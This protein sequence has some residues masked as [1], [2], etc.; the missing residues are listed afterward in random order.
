M[1][2]LNA[3]VLSEEKQ[4]ILEEQLGQADMAALGEAGDLAPELPGFVRYG[5]ASE[6]GRSQQAGRRGRG[7]FWYV[8]SSLSTYVRKVAEGSHV[9]WV[10]VD[11]PQGTPWYVVAV[12]LPPA[13]SQQ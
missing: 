6:Q 3:N 13:S 5:S 7:L 1:L 8:R 12:Y 2:Y 4:A 9:L 11:L 10:Q